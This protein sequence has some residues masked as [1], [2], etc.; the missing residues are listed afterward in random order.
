MT[1]EIQ[2]SSKIMYDLGKLEKSYPN[3][4]PLILTRCKQS[5]SILDNIPNHD[6]HPN[7]DDI[8]EHMD[9]INIRNGISNNV[10]IGQLLDFQKHIGQKTRNSKTCSEVE[11]NFHKRLMERN[12]FLPSNQDT[13]SNQDVEPT[14]VNSDIKSRPRHTIVSR[15]RLLGELSHINELYMTLNDT[16]KWKKYV[17]HLQDTLKTSLTNYCTSSKLY[18]EL[19]IIKGTTEEWIKM[20]D[21]ITQ[22]LQKSPLDQEKKTTIDKMLV[23][24]HEHDQAF[25]IGL[26]KTLD[27]DG[28]LAQMN[29][30]ASTFKTHYQIVSKVIQ[31]LIPAN[32]CKICLIE[33]V[34]SFIDTCGHTMCHLCSDRILGKNNDAPVDMFHDVNETYDS[35][36]CPYCAKQFTKANVKKLYL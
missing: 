10:T 11:T 33:T 14:Q 12:I 2:G 32:C 28:I 35:R 3:I 22:S 24:K 34:D 15:E 5:T 31:P 6:N 16:E 30:N 17:S 25:M 20:Y 26:L 8:D 23:D 21:K 19:N 1:Q 13:A 4:Y 27:V 36:P 29:Q 7:R 9:M 18:T